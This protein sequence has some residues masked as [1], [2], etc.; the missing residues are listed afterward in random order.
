ME[1][2]EGRPRGDGVR[3]GIVV[4]RFN[5][6]VTDRLLAGAVD[7]LR[8]A[9]V[10]DEDI[11]VLS[12]PGAVEIPT[13]ADRLARGGTVDAVV[14][15]GAVIRGATDH[16]DHVCSMVAAGVQRVA[17]DHDMPV[18][19]GVLTTETTE[20]ALE[21]AGGKAGNKGA[22]AALAALEMVDLLA[23]TPQVTA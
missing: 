15:L 4:S 20:Q 23:Q 8:R 7:A 5:D 14:T 1:L 11:T 16:Y 21:R 17:L 10:A 6:L 9:G 3:I 12:V 2:I 22:D 13:A 19:F 18:T